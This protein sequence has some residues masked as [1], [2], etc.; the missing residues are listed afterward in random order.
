MTYI[1]PTIIHVISGL[2]SGG[3]EN[4]LLRLVEHEVAFRHIVVSLSDKGALGDRFEELGIELVCLNFRRGRLN[5]AGLSALWR[6]LYSQKS[7]SLQSWMYHADF[8]AGIIGFILGHKVI[9]NIRHSNFEYRKENLLTILIMFMNAALSHLIPTKIIC[10]AEL[11]KQTHSKLGYNRR[12]MLVIEN[13]I[14]LSEYFPD[15]TIKNRF[16]SRHDIPSTTF[17]IGFVAR[18]NDQKDHK[19]FLTGFKKFIKVNPEAKCVMAGHGINWSNKKLTSLLSQFKLTKN[20]ILLGLVNTSAE[21]MKSIDVNVL[22]SSHG[23][24]YPNVLIEGLACGAPAVATDVGDSA[25][26]IGS[27]GW[28]ISPKNPPQLLSA[29]LVAYSTYQNKDRWNKMRSESVQLVAKR[30]NLTC[31]IQKYHDIWVG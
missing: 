17:L 20:V 12:K 26:I 25:A 30:N 21:I 15:E 1:K 13:G 10:C 4:V 3:A 5:Y 23:E 16:R 31:T 6:L 18:Y 22:T 9:W 24:G 14:D 2:N 28:I 7:L 19:T 29:L 27:C 11:V 8:L